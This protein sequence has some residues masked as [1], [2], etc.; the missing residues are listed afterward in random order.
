MIDML[1]YL[2]YLETAS[3]QDKL[4]ILKKKWFEVAKRFPNIYKGKYE[5]V[6]PRLEKVW[7]YIVLADPT[8]NKQYLQWILQKGISDWTNK[9]ERLMKEDLPKIKEDLNNT[10]F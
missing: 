7:G 4:D 3:L 1:N 2:E 5:E 6:E 10:H 9:N 8:K